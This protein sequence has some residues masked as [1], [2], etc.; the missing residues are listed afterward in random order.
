MRY[1]YYV[2]C[3]IPVSLLWILLHSPHDMSEGAGTFVEAQF[4]LLA[5][6]MFF[7]PLITFIGMLFI[8]AAIAFRK[9]ILGL[10]IATLIAAIPGGYFLVVYFSGSGISN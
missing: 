1:I 6:I 2:I 3:P 10:S 9:S 5:L 4:G 7:C 8:G